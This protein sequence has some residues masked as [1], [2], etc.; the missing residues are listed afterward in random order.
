MS[1]ANIEYWGISMSIEEMKTFVRNHFEQFVNR[2]NLDI[3]DVNF[4]R[5]FVDHGADVPPGTPPGPAGAKQYVGSALKKFPDLKVTLED[6]IAEGDKVVVRNV[7]RCTDPDSGKKIQFG[8]IV[9]WRI[10][11]GQLSERWA[12]LEAPKPAS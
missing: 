2:K 3:A 1:A 10:V 6:I 4:A 9:I 5:D 8:G 11:R 12:Y 7:W